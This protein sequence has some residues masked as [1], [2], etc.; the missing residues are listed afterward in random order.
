[1]TRTFKAIVL[2]LAVALASSVLVAS[3]PIA[4]GTTTVVTDKKA[5]VTVT[6]NDQINPGKVTAKFSKPH[7]ALNRPVQL[8]ILS[9]TRVWTNVG[10]PVAMTATG[11]ATFSK[12]EP[13]QTSSYRAVAD[14]YLQLVKVVTTSAKSKVI[15]DSAATTTISPVAEASTGSIKVVF[16]KS[17]R[18]KNR[19]VQLQVE[20]SY[21]WAKV[22]KP[23]KMSS[24]GAVTFKTSPSVTDNYRALAAAYK[25]KLQAATLKASSTWKLERNY[26]FDTGAEASSD[27]TTWHPGDYSFRKCAANEPVNT[28]MQ[29]GA[30]KLKLSKNTSTEALNAATAAGCAFPKGKVAY[31]NAMVYTNGTFTISEGIVAAKVRFPTNTDMHGGVW[32]SNSTGSPEIDIIESYGYAGRHSKYSKTTSGIHQA[33]SYTDHQNLP[34]AK[35]WEKTYKD[36]L[37]QTLVNLRYRPASW[38][39]QDHVVS[40]EFT[41]S[42]LIFRIDGKK[43]G[44]L[45]RETPETDYFLVMS[46]ITTPWE[47]SQA[48]KAPKVPA[49]M[50]VDWV[51]AWVAE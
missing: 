11:V 29:D 16:S 44:D 51:R 40:V 9:V 17:H 48:K 47:L 24:S 23:V 28:A 5:T 1:M 50:S 45:Y 34:K 15:T 39:K 31:D 22:G 25:K 38:Y 21:G 19:P 35:G 20:R 13:D 18:V 2:A 32:L 3:A 36:G 10:D 49:T 41:T 12:D 33:M 37:S 6:P 7:I 4:A 46:L 42:R 43:V 8:Q 27:W 14:P 30:A 26:T